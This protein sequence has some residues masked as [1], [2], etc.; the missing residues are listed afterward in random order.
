MTIAKQCM[1]VKTVL[2]RQND[3]QWMNNEIQLLIVKRNKLHKK[4]KQ[5]NLATDWGRFRKVRNYVL[6]RIRLRKID[7]LKELDN[8]ASDPNIFGQKDWLRLAKIFLNKKGIDIDVI[9]PLEHNGNILF[10]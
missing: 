10:K 8:K 5:A 3:A 4:A 2:V 6:S 9:L 7:Y 1:P